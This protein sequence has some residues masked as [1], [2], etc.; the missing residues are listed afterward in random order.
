[1]LGHGKCVDSKPF[2]AGGH[3]WKLSYYPH[4]YKDSKSGGPS[5]LL[6]L[7]EKRFRLLDMMADATAAYDVSVLDVDGNQL[8]YHH[9][10][11]Q[12]IYSTQGKSGIWTDV[13][14]SK[15][16]E[17]PETERKEAL[18]RLKDDSLVVRCDVTVKRLKEES[19]VRWF[20]Q[21]FLD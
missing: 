17:V 6:R 9:D 8:Y 2:H 12:S 15:A 11:A 18:C 3:R 5:M 7:M 14:E 19:R 20:L 1:M 10:T 4:G 21:R 16:A 13:C